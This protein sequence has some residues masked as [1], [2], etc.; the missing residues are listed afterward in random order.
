MDEYSNEDDIEA[1]GVLYKKYYKELV[2]HIEIIIQNKYLGIE[3]E[4]IVQRTF[5]IA[6]E[7][8]KISRFGN[9][10]RA[11]LHKMAHDLCI[12][13]MR[14]CARE[15]LEYVIDDNSNSEFPYEDMN[16]DGK[17]EIEESILEVNKCVESIEDANKRVAIALKFS[18]G[19]SN[20]EIGKVLGIDRYRAT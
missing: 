14:I 2:V 16:V 19:F 1:L 12:D 15:K 13:Q 9:K 8:R 20:A 17:L 7:K 11:L 3:P 10:S 5:K 4:D 6:M 18:E